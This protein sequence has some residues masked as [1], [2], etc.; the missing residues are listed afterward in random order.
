MPFQKI[1]SNPAIDGEEERKTE[2]RERK[3]SVGRL[4]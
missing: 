2:R 4:K 3:S 1:S